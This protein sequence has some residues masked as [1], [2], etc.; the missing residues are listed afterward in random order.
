MGMGSEGESD[1]LREMLLET[2]PLLLAVTM[3]VSVPRCA[4]INHSVGR[5][6]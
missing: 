4:G 2:N 5:P 3:L 6:Q 1:M